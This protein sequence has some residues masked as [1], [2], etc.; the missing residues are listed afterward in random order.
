[1]DELFG[2]SMDLIMYGLVGLL[3][4][5]LLS[6]VYVFLANRVMFRLGVR[7]IPRRRAQT[8]L[9]VLGLMLST[10]IISAAFTTGDTVDRSITSDVY[11][12]LG[13]LDETLQLRFENED[14]FE[15]ETLALIQERTFSASVV[16]PV[17]D[18]LAANPNLDYVIPA[19]ARVAVAVNDQKRLSAP[20]FSLLG[21]D[22]ARARDLPDIESTSGRHLSLD[23]LGANEIYLN[24]SAAD[25]I[26]VR[27]GDSFSVFVGDRSVGRGQRPQ[28]GGRRRHIHPPPG[29]RDAPGGRASAVRRPRPD[30]DDCRLQPG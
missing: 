8:T 5:S 11:S 22:P 1:M 27:T 13:S 3:A 9:I 6:V 15:N 7:N 16:E 20:D 25:E 23:Q 19:F 28:A 26:D 10:V 17:V 14:D 2:V 18:A 24:E 12:V 30:H 29:R 4:V 21:L